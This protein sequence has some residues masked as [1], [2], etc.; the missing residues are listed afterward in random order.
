MIGD[1]LTLAAAG[2][3]AGLHSASWGAYKDSPYEPFKAGKYLRSVALGVLV[4]F[5]GA[6]FLRV[7][8]VNTVNLGVMYAFAVILERAVT[9]LMKG[10]IREEPQ[11]KYRIPSTVHVLGRIIKN[12]RKRLFTGLAFTLAF[13]VFTTFMFG[14]TGMGSSNRL[15]TGTLFGLTG[16]MLIAL[17]GGLKDAPIEGFDRLKFMRSPCVAAAAGAFLSQYTSEY[18]LIMLASMGLERM[19]TEAYKSFVKTRAPGKFKAEKPADRM[20]IERR[21]VFAVPYIATWAAFIL[22]LGHTIA[23]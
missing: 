16:G 22:F 14:I 4:A 19:V 5:G 10:Y 18:G 3:L 21:G 15:V 12:R 1:A 6:L 11:D 7:E 17:G 2:A 13:I 20:W 23:L 8:G 9:E